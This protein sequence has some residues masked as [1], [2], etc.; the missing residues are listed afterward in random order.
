MSEKP[1]SLVHARGGPVIEYGNKIIWRLRCASWSPEGQMLLLFASKSLRRYC[2]RNSWALVNPQAFLFLLRVIFLRVRESSREAGAKKKIYFVFLQGHTLAFGLFSNPLRLIL[3]LI[4]IWTNSRQNRRSGI[5]GQTTGALMMTLPPAMLIC[6]Y[7]TLLLKIVISIK[8]RNKACMCINPLWRV[9][10]PSVSLFLL[11][12]RGGGTLQNFY[13]GCSAPR[14]IPLHFVY[15]FDRKGTPFVCLKLKKK[16]TRLTCFHNWP[17]SWINHQ[18][19]KSCHFHVVLNKLNDTAIRC[20]T[21]W[22]ISLPF[23]IP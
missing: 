18:N 2:G 7:W 1:C 3:L 9:I 11:L 10:N 5:C 17:V 12:S 8:S 4:A 15:H 19:R 21:K 20:V 13:T 6:T 16:C 23:Q 22:Q 14:F